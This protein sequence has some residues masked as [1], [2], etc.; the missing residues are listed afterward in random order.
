MSTINQAASKL[1]FTFPLLLALTGCI[2]GGPG[3][4]DLP[5]M[6]ALNAG[7]VKIMVSSNQLVIK[8]IERNGTV[9]YDCLCG[10]QITKNEMPAH[11]LNALIAIEDERF[12]E[13]Y[14]GVD[15]IGIASAIADKLQSPFAK[16]RGASTLNQQLCKNRLLNSSGSFSRKYDDAQCAIQLES[17]MTKDEILVAYLNTA[18]FGKLKGKPAIYGVEQAARTYFGKLAADLNVYESAALVAMLKS[19][20]TLNPAEDKKASSARTELV[21]SKM[22]NLG[23]ITEKEFKEAKRVKAQKGNRQPYVFEHRYFGDYAIKSLQAA[24]VLLDE[25]DHVAITLEVMTQTG[26]QRAFEQSLKSFKISKNTKAAFATMKMDGRLVALLGDQNYA[27][28]QF[29]LITDDRLEAAST[30]KPFIYAAAI[31]NGLKTTD[32]L[33]DKANSGENWSAELLKNQR[34]LISMLDALAKS[35]NIATIRLSRKVGFEQVVSLAERLG[36]KANFSKEK[37][38]AL[39][40]VQVSPLE[41]ITAYAA[42]GNGG[43]GVSPYA[44]LGVAD[45][46]GNQKFWRQPESWRVLNKSVAAQMDKMLKS[47]VRDGTGKAAN[48]I[49]GAAGKT[50]TGSKNASAS[51]IGYTEGQVTGVFVQKE[52]DAKPLKIV[53]SDVAAIWAVLVKSFQGR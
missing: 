45:R 13:R 33:L 42:F 29:N 35:A 43:I 8:K 10:P 5:E 25:G 28:R 19:P 16:L 41:M 1:A 49:P 20:A 18:Y 21:L 7:Q 14:V 38:L 31:G 52:K 24:G 9:K 51:F 30:F 39:G 32:K 36:I 12:M 3:P 15:V 11:L 46:N 48:I 34:G 44:V 37:S 27:A 50:G 6:P 2:S 4:E 22:L 53:G 26:E 47:V 40:A 17:V 23:F